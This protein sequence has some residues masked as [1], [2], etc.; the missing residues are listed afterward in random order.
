[1]NI[2][3]DDIGV[4]VTLSF[5]GAGIGVLVGAV[6]ASVV[7]N[8]KQKKQKEGQNEQMDHEG[9]E[10]EAP[11]SSEETQPETNQS[12][13]QTARAGK[14]NG[15]GNSWRTG[16]ERR[17][18]ELEATA[19]QRQLVLSGAL[20]LED[21]EQELLDEVAES[22]D[23]DDEPMDYA[24]FYEDYA[25][26][27]DD[28]EVLDELPDILLSEERPLPGVYD[29]MV[30]LVWDGDLEKLYQRRNNR[31]VEISLDSVGFS[32]GDLEDAI[33]ILEYGDYAS[34]GRS[35]YILETGTK[36]CYAL[37]Y[38]VVPQTEPPKEVK[39]GKSTGSDSD[40]TA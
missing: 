32:E 37:S 20:T 22:A 6:V 2:T 28:P 18:D 7:E 10:E 15:K 9:F 1:M 12:A 36:K 39:N 34:S 23:E 40:E 19:V 14:R 35:V 31:L 8:R 26:P 24:D 5:V 29:R 27:E 13:T 38:Q 30:P 17:L 21:L 16:L 11:I 3:R 4:I 25:E 33:D